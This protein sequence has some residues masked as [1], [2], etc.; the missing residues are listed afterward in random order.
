MIAVAEECKPDVSLATL[1]MARQLGVH[2]MYP[3]PGT[4]NGARACPA[5]LHHAHHL[6][7]SG[8]ALQSGRPVGPGS[9]CKPALAAA[10]SPRQGLVCLAD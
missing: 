5:A 1:E 3:L 10:G 4:V 9:V 7:Q 6:L 8:F 2:T